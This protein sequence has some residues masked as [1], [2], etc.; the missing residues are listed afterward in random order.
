MRRRAKTANFGII[1][2]ISAWGLAERLHISR[3]EGKELIDGYF[4][5]YPGVKKYMEESVEKARKNE[6]VETIM[7][8]RRYLRDINSRNAVVRG[9][10]ERN[11][12]NAPIQGSAADIIKMAMICIQKR[13]Q[14]EGLMSRM[15]IQVHDELNFKCH[16]S[17]QYLLK[18]LVTNCMEHVIKLS[19]PLTVSTGF[20]NNWYEAH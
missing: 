1:Y 10:A 18:S 14:E 7:G 15:I 9:M 5:L 4:D 11:A 13:I 8:R 12:I 17:E 6:F 3:K 2:G 19:V 16:K 20:G